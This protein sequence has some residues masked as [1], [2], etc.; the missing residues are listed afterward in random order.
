MPQRAAARPPTHAHVFVESLLTTG[1][2]NTARWF[3][4]VAS[5]LRRIRLVA[6]VKAA[7]A[8]EERYANNNLGARSPIKSWETI[9]SRG[10]YLVSIRDF[11]ALS[12][13]TLLPLGGNAA[14]WILSISGYYWNLSSLS[15]ASAAEPPTDPFD[16]H[17]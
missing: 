15:Y 12:R 11:S 4:C 8:D 2:H 10:Y 9:L 5:A 7:M 17:C 14:I 16:V 3:A 13:T 1:D 6:L